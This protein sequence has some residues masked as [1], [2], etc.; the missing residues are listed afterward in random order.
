MRNKLDRKK[1]RGEEPEK[2]VVTAAAAESKEKKRKRTGYHKT[3]SRCRE[4]ATPYYRVRRTG[5]APRGEAAAR[6]ELRQ[7]VP[8]RRRKTRSDR[9]QRQG[10]AGW[11]PKG[12]RWRGRRNG[13]QRFARHD[14][15]GRLPTHRQEGTAVPRWAEVA[16]GPAAAVTWCRGEVLGDARKQ[17]KTREA[18]K[19][20][21]LGEARQRQQ[22]SKRVRGTKRIRA[23]LLWRL[24]QKVASAQEG[25]GKKMGA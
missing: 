9:R 20:K 6:K 2:A 8:R 14:W 1:R 13:D 24:Q 17:R 7:R 16:P 22:V 12:R 25:D 10:V 23:T 4:E 5:P 3:R 15:R 19:E 11:N 21:G 18:L